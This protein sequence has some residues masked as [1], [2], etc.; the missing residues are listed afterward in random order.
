MSCPRAVRNQPCEH[1]VY[2]ELCTTRAVQASGLKCGVCRCAVQRLVVVP[3]NPAG[4]P[5]LLRRIQTYLSKPEPEGSTFEGV[6]REKE[7]DEED[8]DGENPRFPIDAQGHATVPEGVTELPACAFEGCTS[9]ISITLPTS[10]TRIGPNFFRDCPSLALTRLP[11]GLTSI[12][13][14]A[15]VDC[16][17]LALTRLPDGLTSIGDYAFVDYTSL[18]LTSLLDSLTRIGD[19]AFAGCDSLA[20]TS[21]PDSLTSIGDRAFIN[22]ARSW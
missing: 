8:D 10:L 20:L 9:L 12:G 5:P 19:C 2:C 21:L 4:D 11:D 18:A 16:T 22:C 13:D 1:A 17:S 6:G 7:G 14:Y 15:F 3:V